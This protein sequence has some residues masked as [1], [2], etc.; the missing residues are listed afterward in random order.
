MFL[1][2]LQL[3]FNYN[4]FLVIPWLPFKTGKRNRNK[5]WAPF[6]PHLANSVPAVVKLRVK[7]S[8]VGQKKEMFKEL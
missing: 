3:I 7:R 4:L 2:I 1:T 6:C 8:T 5:C